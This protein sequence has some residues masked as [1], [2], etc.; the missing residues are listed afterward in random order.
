MHDIIYDITGND[1]QA[2]Q[3]VIEFLKL[4]ENVRQIAYKWSANDTVFRDE[5]YDYI[6]NNVQLFTN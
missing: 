6:E 4:P 1:L 2:E 3:L 5:A